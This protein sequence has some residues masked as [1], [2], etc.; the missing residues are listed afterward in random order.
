MKCK[1]CGHEIS[2]TDTVC[3]GC[4][5]SVEELKQNNNIMSNEGENVTVAPAA[6]PVVEPVVES[7]ENTE[8]PVAETTEAP[9]E[10]GVTETPAVETETP[11]EETAAPVETEV[12]I[13]VEQ[14]NETVGENSE[15]TQ[16]EE[17]KVEASAEM[18][19]EEKSIYDGADVVI[20]APLDSNVALDTAA[21]EEKAEEAKPEKKKG[22]AGKAILVVILL[23][24]LAI[25]GCAGYFFFVYGS[26][27]AVLSR[28]VNS[29]LAVTQ[30]N[31]KYVNVKANVEVTNGVT[32]K[33][34]FDSKIELSNLVG[35]TT[36][37]LLGETTRNVTIAN[38]GENSYINFGDDQNIKFA[39][40]Y[41]SEKLNY[42]YYVP[43]ATHMSNAKNII[44]ELKNVLPSVFDSK[45][46]T[47]EFTTVTV[48]QKN[49]G[50]T[51]FS[52]VLDQTETNKLLLNLANEFKKNTSIMTNL[53]A[54]YSLP[55]PEV[56]NL[57]DGFVRNLSVSG[58][59]F[60]LYTDYLTNNYYK[61]EIIIKGV[62]NFKLT[63]NYGDDNKISSISVVVG[64]DQIEVTNNYKHIEILRTI[65]GKV[66]KYVLDIDYT[67]IA[68]VDVVAPE[69]FYEYST[70]GKE[71][72]ELMVSNDKALTIAYNLVVKDANVVYVEK[73]APV[74]NTE[75]E[76]TETS[77]DTQTTEPTVDSQATADTQTTPSVDAQTNTNES[78]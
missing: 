8:V 59:E 6:E 65:E 75:V 31:E 27:A 67:G 41:L 5:T 32:S 25:G 56:S 51:K 33:Y 72:L 11:V 53:M 19:S 20:G 69:E 62:N 2:E 76:N 9:V 44:T 63:L 43:Y 71:A 68:S 37:S 61:A 36:I 39:D 35:N 52:Y 15:V 74:E 30:A 66:T 47:R 3:P 57:I 77:T 7:T 24:V 17:P 21:K 46:L 13:P 38:D 42:S 16:T 45:K 73:E 29:T 1:I 60:N 23:L 70:I 58:F 54:I 28:A 22:G 50:A 12:T 10:N 49:M 18:S 64:N 55:Q 40:S 4:D 78:E 48:D 34:A 26:P 14:A